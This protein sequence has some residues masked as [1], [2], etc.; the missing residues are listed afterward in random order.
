MS[1]EDSMDHLTHAE[2]TEAYVIPW[3]FK[4]ED[5]E[6]G[7]DCMLIA[8]MIGDEMQAIS[9]HVGYLPDLSPSVA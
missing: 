5:P 7:R 3:H 8:T 6:H 9:L 1:L 4:A 2:P